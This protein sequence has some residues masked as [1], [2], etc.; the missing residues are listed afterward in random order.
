MS[1]SVSRIGQS[2][3]RSAS[4]LVDQSI[5]HDSLVSLL[6]SHSVSVSVPVHTCAHRP[7]A[8]LARSRF[9]N[10]LPRTYILYTYVYYHTHTMLP[11]LLFS[12]SPLPPSSYATVG[13]K[14][15]ARETTTPPRT[16]PSILRARTVFHV[17]GKSRRAWSVTTFNP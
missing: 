9:P 4:R 17:R 5:S 13:S 3:D 14:R 7:F 6:I 12:P 8:P 10:L 11:I 15:R 16:N 1:V 2:F